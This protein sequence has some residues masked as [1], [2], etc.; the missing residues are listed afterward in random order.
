MVLGGVKVVTLVDGGVKKMTRGV[1]DTR[2]IIP[3][4][5]SETG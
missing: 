4:N 1:E 3:K 5:P 2:S